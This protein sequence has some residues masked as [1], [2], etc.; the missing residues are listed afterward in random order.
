MSKVRYAI[1]IGTWAIRIGRLTEGREGPVFDM[2][3]EIPYRTDAPAPL[4]G[5]FAQYEVSRESLQEYTGQIL[6]QAGLGSI[7]AAVT[8]PD[9]FCSVKYLELPRAY[10]SDDQS[11]DYLIWRIREQL[12]STLAS[13]CVMDFQLLGPMERDGENFSRI[14]VVLIKEPLVNELALAMSQAGIVAPWFSIN[15]IDCHNLIDR[16]AMGAGDQ[17][18]LQGVEPA[19]QCLLHT[20]HFG[21]HLIFH[22]RGTP[23]YSRL[24]DRAGYHFSQ[25]LA[26]LRDVSFE[27][28]ERIKERECLIPSELSAYGD[29]QL[30]FSGFQHLFAEYLREIDMTFRSF[31]G[32]FP[33]RDLSS[34]ILCGGSSALGGLAEFLERMLKLPCSLLSLSDYVRLGGVEAAQ[35]PEQAAKLLRFAPLCGLLTGRTEES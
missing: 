11:R 8:I 27:D 6:R 10:L 24:F 13:E 32:K 35:S 5:V 18:E 12:P 16:T 19:C 4:K 9:Q 25:N 33:D 28:A 26:A 23:V 20:G 30:D 3:H 31:R 22:S 17:E 34:I 1:D 14:M 2:F 7:E 29:S 21:C 15:S